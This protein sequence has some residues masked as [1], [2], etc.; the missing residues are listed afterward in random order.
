MPRRGA[1]LYGPRAKILGRDL[2]RLSTPRDRLDAAGAVPSLRPVCGRYTNTR[3]KS[4]EIQQR[5]E[6]KLGID[7]PDHDRGFERF[8][9]APTQEVLA[10]VEDV[11][12]RR[13][14]LLRW[15]LVPSWATDLKVGYRMINARAETLQERPAYRG[16]VRH[17][18]HRCL[19]LAD[20]YYEWQ[21]PED[22]RQPRRPLHFT[23][24]EGEPF[25]FAGLWTTWSGSGGRMVSSCT[26]VT[27]E[28]N[29]LARPIHERM[30]VL[31]DDPE[32]WAAWL[33]PGIDAR[34][35]RELLIPLAGKHM[36]VR[37][38][39]P[40]VNSGRHEGPGCLAELAA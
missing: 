13:T 3:S 23:L 32:A 39:S 28:A 18:S 15:G 6:A 29:E 11:D 22:P 9:I 16:L 36:V 14:E 1:K 12:G 26:I 40:V 5:L 33:D 7:P 10:V 2:Y 35:A 20:G 34:A 21:K 38:A 17:A 24:H 25:C 8:N 37:P 30:P 19:I 27:C 31:L 4:D